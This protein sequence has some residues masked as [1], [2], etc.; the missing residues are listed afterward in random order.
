MSVSL[1]DEAL[2]E[3]IKTWTGESNITVLR[4]DETSRLF[5]QIVD[6]NND[7]TIKLPIIAISRD[8]DVTLLDTHKQAKTFI[9]AKLASNQT[10]TIT[11]NVVP[12]SISYQI[13]VYTS[14][15]K[16][17]DM[18]LREFVFNFINYP[19]LQVVI[20]YNGYNYEH[21]STL[22]LNDSISDNSDI[23]ERHFPDEFTRF[24]YK[25]T[26]DDAYL[27]SIPINNN[28][29]AID[30]T[31]KVYDRTTGDVVETGVIESAKLND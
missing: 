16:E 29:Q 22:Y 23:S 18:Y 7:S 19:K 13:D 17:A 20:P 14:T 3:K 25:I 4:P 15:I 2:V 30:T 26:V 5:K 28:V 12:I 1:Y 21:F 24:T 6:T 11:M 27:F 9:G 10:N 31:Y 8:R